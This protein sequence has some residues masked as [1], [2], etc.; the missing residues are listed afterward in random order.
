MTNTKANIFSPKSHASKIEIVNQEPIGIDLDAD[1]LSG[2][3]L[4]K[5]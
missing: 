3:S 2:G 1:I 5:D 4:T